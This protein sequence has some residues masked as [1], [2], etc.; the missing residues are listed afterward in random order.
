MWHVN[1]KLNAFWQIDLKFL[2]TFC[3]FYLTQN[4]SFFQ[5]FFRRL[6]QEVRSYCD[7]FLQWGAKNID[8]TD[9]KSLPDRNPLLT[10]YLDGDI[11]GKSQAGSFTELWVWRSTKDDYPMDPLAFSTHQGSNR[12]K[13]NKGCSIW[14]TP[15]IISPSTQTITEKFK[16]VVFEVDELE[17]RDISI[18]KTFLPLL[19][20]QDSNS[21]IEKILHDI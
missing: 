20:N 5:K 15:K 12:R 8:R 11:V 1:F 4:A 3:L 18:Q 9:T 16:I 19:V 7:I 14:K 17:Y 6:W 13:T 21:E 2:D 10:K